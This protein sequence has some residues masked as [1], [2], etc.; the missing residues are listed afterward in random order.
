VDAP[1][2]GNYGLTFGARDLAPGADNPRGP[3]A[4]ERLLQNTNASAGVRRILQ[5]P[6]YVVMVMEEAGYY[7]TIPL[8]G[9]PALGPKIRQ[10]LGD[11]RGH[12]EGNTLVVEITNINDQQNGGALIPSQEQNLYPGSGATLRVIERYTRL[13]A[14][15][16][17]YRYTIDDPETYTRPYT[18]LHDLTRDDEYKMSP[19]QCRENNE[20]L[21][22]ILT[23]ARTDEQ[24]ALAATAA[25]VAERKRRLEELKAE[26]AEWSKGR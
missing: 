2:I 22:G 6:G 13:D 10:W 19:A 24:G 1:R 18:V 3:D 26:W 16:L 8:N 4:P 12:W 11:A 21:V 5:A 25:D 15:T 7:Y 23:A 17:E 14:N 9:H 20:G